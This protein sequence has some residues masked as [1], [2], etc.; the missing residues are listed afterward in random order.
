[1]TDALVLPKWRV[2]IEV[3]GCFWHRHRDCP[4][5]T[6]PATRPDFWQD[7]FDANVRR[8]EANVEALLTAGWRVLIVW[9]CAMTPG[10]SEPVL[11]EVTA[12]VIGSVHH[13]IRCREIG[14]V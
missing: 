8:D 7:K 10:L 3:R 14:S 1:M 9:E 12:F 6:T 11:D 5:A 13:E 4:K 2:V